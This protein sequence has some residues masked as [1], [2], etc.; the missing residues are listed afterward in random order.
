MHSVVSKPASPRDLRLD[1]FRGLAL[2]CIFID[3]IPGNLWALFT[4]QAIGLSDA[5]EVF[6]LISGYTAGLVY[7]GAFD[8][9]GFVRASARIYARVWQLYVA[10]V[11]LFM[12]YMALVAHST[13]TI[14]NPL[15]AEE[16]GV[17]DFL[18]Q[19]DEAILMALLLVF[20]PAFM[21]I[22]PMYIVLLGGLPLLLVGF[23]RAP[24]VTLAASGLLYVAVW[25]F[26]DLQ[27]PAY[28]GPD[29]GWFFNPFAWQ[30][31]FYL[32]AYLGY[33]N[34]H[35]GIPWVK[36][37]A[38]LVGAAVV[39]AFGLVT[40]VSWIVH[41]FRPE[42]PAILLK[43]IAPYLSKTDLSIFRL[44]NVLALAVLVVF[45]VA[46]QA[47][48]LA[49]RWAAPFILCGRHSL[50]VFCLGILLSL[51]SHLVLTELYGGVLL[52]FAV[53]AAGVALLV[54]AAWMMDWFRRGDARAEPVTRRAVG[55]D[56]EL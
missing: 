21:D 45:L 34:L 51:V 20:Q 19:P 8:R 31:L 40:E 33:R 27:I 48:W 54:G 53:S 41:K 6:I 43:Q 55:A 3:H 39:A 2:F 26:K 25:I 14:A 7:G 50:H 12:M 24:F 10:H 4:L 52:Q 13:A 16:V 42:V 32:G 5:A 29:K 9:A 47:R 30:L 35:G 38:I 17:A 46:P 37:R 1:F 49:S 56:G 22:L 18:K 28:P 15:Y 23:A 11:F 36:S 44:A